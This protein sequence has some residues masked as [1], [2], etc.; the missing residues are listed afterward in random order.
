MRLPDHIQAG[1]GEPALGP[2]NSRLTPAPPMVWPVPWSHPGGPG[3][4]SKATAKAMPG[5]G[6][7]HEG[8]TQLARAK[9]L[10]TQPGTCTCPI[11]FMLSNN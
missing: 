7:H 9:R 10:G 3:K 2:Q 4:D 11:D 5:C 1:G 6:P 8:T